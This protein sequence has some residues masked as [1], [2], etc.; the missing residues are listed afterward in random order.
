MASTESYTNNLKN[1]DFSTQHVQQNME[2]S[3]FVG[4]HSV[5]L[6]A[7]Y[8]RV[9]DL[10]TDKDRYIDDDP[11]TDISMD[12]GTIAYPIGVIDSSA[13]QQDRNL[14]QIF[15][16]GSTRSYLMS[17]RT[18]TQMSINR[19]LY[20]G[21]TML[22]CLYAYY[23]TDKFDAYVR[24]AYMPDSAYNANKI[25]PPVL[26]AG[27]TVITDLPDIKDAPG[28][29]DFWMNLASDLFS[30]PM[31]LVIYVSDNNKNKVAAMYLEE[32]YIQNHS[33][34]MSANSVV[35]AESCTIRCDRIHPIAVRTTFRN[36]L[37]SADN[38]GGNG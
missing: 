23:P 22:R 17:A 36:A 20:N 3:D 15:E 16:I 25:M 13:I 24:N 11:N 8:P 9:S 34:Q 32:C 35:M 38:Y 4:S 27:S 19:I 26:R 6:C 31:G 28:Y 14:Q 1:W 21:P 30:H 10:A 29:G 7:T 12:D 2:G 5:I 18:I 37:P 33:F